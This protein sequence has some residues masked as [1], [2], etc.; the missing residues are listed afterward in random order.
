MAPTVTTGSVAADPTGDVRTAW[1]TGNGAATSRLVVGDHGVLVRVALA[2]GLDDLDL[3]VFAEDGSLAGQSTGP[4]AQ[5]RVDLVLPAAGSYTVIV[6]GSDVAGA[7][8]DYSLS[9]WVLDG[10]VAAGLDLVR[11]PAQAVENGR[12]VV[13]IA[14]S[15]AAPGVELLGAV[16]HADD[17]GTMAVTAVSVDTSQMAAPGPLAVRNP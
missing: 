2:G 17:Q 10:S 12:G 4:R 15:G 13:S 3:Y 5:E 9:E 7:T 16:T 11:S 14:W 1:D 6:H 8:A